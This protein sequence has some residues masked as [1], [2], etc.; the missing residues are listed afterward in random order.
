MLFPRLK[1]YN[2]H[3][4]IPLINESKWSYEVFLLLSQPNNMQTLEVGTLDAAST[5]SIPKANPMAIPCGSTLSY[6]S[7]KSHLNL[8]I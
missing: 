1:Y 4:L 7:N 6:T 8:K 3:Y 2:K 5:Y